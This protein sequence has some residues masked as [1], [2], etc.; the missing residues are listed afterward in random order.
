MK[1]PLLGFTLALMLVLTARADTITLT[2]GR[3]FAEAKIISSSA[4]RVCIRH[5]G[6]IV[7]VERALLPPEL[8]T[9]YPADSQAVAAEDATRAADAEK[10]AAQEEARAER[11]RTL[12]ERPHPAPEPHVASAAEIED[13]VVGYAKR[14][15]R[16]KYQSGSNDSVTFN[17]SVDT[18]PPAEMTGWS[19]QWR[20]SGEA[21]FTHYRS[22]GWG[23]Y[24]KETRRFEAI[25]HAPVGDRP[26]VKDFTLR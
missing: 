26:R 18:E 12:A 8:A 19:D 22:S 21:S 3:T 6:G 13:T 1:Y 11:H 17:V 7:Q 10:K 25:I 24:Q 5:A 14:Y 4:G 9:R 23:N 15:F 16:D 20:V 2:D